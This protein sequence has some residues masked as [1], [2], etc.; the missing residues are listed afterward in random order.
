MK[1]SYTPNTYTFLHFIKMDQKYQCQFKFKKLK[2]TIPIVEKSNQMKN[3]KISR[4][5]TYTDLLSIPS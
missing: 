3:E 2:K 4:S 1:N 5:K